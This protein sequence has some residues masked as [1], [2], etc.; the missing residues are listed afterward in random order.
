MELEIG[1]YAEDDE[2]D[3]EDVFGKVGGACQCGF[4][5]FVKFRP[6]MVHDFCSY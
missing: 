6:D 4:V 5:S 2:E 3:Y 1:K